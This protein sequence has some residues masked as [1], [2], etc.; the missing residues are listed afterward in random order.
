MAECKSELTVNLGARNMVDLNEL[1]YLA[2]S[3]PDTIEDDHHDRPS[4]KVCGKI[5]ATL[6]D[7]LHLNVMLHAQQAQDA[8]TLA[9]AV[10]LELWSGDHLAGVTVELAGAD[11]DMLAALLTSAWRRKAPSAL[12]RELGPESAPNQ[13]LQSPA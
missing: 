11:L 3:F 9:P 6:P 5:F 12:A 8:A 4:F 13:A 7:D 1:R 10:C 2:L